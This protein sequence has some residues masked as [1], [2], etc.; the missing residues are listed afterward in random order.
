[1]NGLQLE[2]TRLAWQRTALTFAVLGG[3]LIRGGWVAGSV[4]FAGAVGCLVCAR[5]RDRRAAPLLI[6]TV[7][8]WSVLVALLAVLTSRS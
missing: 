8:G 4:A 5:L 2:R 7:A 6:L 1:M 3:L